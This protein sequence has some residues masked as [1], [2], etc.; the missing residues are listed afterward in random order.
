MTDDTDQPVSPTRP[1]HRPDPDAT[2]A[3]DD[4]HADPDPDPDDA[5]LAPT[6]PTDAEIAQREQDRELNSGEENPG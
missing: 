5:F 4:R 1:Q 6:H 3:T 2:D